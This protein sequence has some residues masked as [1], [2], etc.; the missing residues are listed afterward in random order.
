MD[1]MPMVAPSACRMCQ[2]KDSRIMALERELAGLRKDKERLDWMDVYRGEKLVRTW[3][4][5]PVCGWAWKWGNKV[6][7][8][9]RAALDAARE[10]QHE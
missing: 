8:D 2:A 9:L 1:N 3:V 5:Y 7:A 4:R 6:F 10:A